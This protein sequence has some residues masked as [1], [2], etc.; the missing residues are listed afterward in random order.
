MY[1]LSLFRLGRAVGRELFKF[2]VQTYQNENMASDMRNITTPKLCLKSF[3]I[4][5]IIIINIYIIHI[6]IVLAL[7]N[8]PLNRNVFQNIHFLHG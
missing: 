6:I 2:F 4:S 1:I 8:I 7:N 3:I 5:Y